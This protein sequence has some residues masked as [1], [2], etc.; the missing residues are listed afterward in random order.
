MKKSISCIAV[1]PVLMLICVIL[2][3]AVSG[4]FLLSNRVEAVYG[5]PRA[6][7][8][9]LTYLRLAWTLVR[10][11]AEL[12]QPQG[13]PDAPTVD[14]V[15]APGDAPVAVAARLKQ[16]GLIPSVSPWLDYLA[17]KGLDTGLQAGTFRL[18]AAQSPV[19]IAQALQGGDAQVTTFTMQPGWRAEE[20]AAALQTAGLQITAEAFLAQVTSPPEAFA[21]RFDLPHGATLE[22]FLYPE[23]YDLP[24][25]TD[26]ATLVARMLSAFIHAMP[27][28]RVAAYREHGLTVYQAVT[29]ASIVQREA[30]LEEEMPLIA[31]VFYNR[32]Q[33][34]MPLE[35]DP[36]VQ[37]ALGYDAATATWWPSLTAIDLRINSPYNTYLYAGLPPGPIANPGESALQAVA[38]PAD[39]TYLFFRATCDGS[40]RHLFATTYAE[41]L[42][43][44]CP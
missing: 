1:L 24:R 15:I 43:N 23:T 32:L 31:S 11:E 18:S 42:N 21:R 16:A 12:T 22:G 8:G 28:D 4:A 10:H 6:D 9:A 40:G 5:P 41:H 2:F 29:L 7:I 30:V 20:A 26:A 25:G 36:T 35:A 44:A 38:A 39:T 19:A 13:A 3:G 37:Y 33:A 34:G 27:A 17:Y 14:I